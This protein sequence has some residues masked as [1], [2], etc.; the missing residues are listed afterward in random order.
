MSARFDERYSERTRLDVED[1]LE[2]FL[3]ER[4]ERVEAS[5][6]EVVLDKLLRH[7]CKVCARYKPSLI[8]ADG[9]VRRTFVPRQRAKPGNPGERVCPRLCRRL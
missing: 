4:H 3:V 5:Q 1:H 2:R 7:L 9:A 6:I 8:A